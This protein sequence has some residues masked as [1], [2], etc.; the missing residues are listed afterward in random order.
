MVGGSSDRRNFSR[1]SASLETRVPMRT[2]VLLRGLASDS[3]DRSAHDDADIDAGLDGVVAPSTPISRVVT[4]ASA[5]SSCVD[6]RN[7]WSVIRITSAF[8]NRAAR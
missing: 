7:E 5:S 6:Q 4:S 8:N 1:T 3:R 2:K